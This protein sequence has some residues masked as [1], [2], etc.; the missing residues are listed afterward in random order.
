[1]RGTLPRL[2]G[3]GCWVAFFAD[4]LVFIL[5]GLELQVFDEG[6]V[7]LRDGRESEVRGE[8]GWVVCA[9]WRNSQFFT[10][11]PPFPSAPARHSRTLPPPRAAADVI[12]IGACRSLKCTI[13]PLPLKYFFGFGRDPGFWFSGFLII[14]DS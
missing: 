9:R 10:A 4:D 6:R 1:M 12:E 5:D 11:L 7:L 8:N 13:S 14:A 2:A 3:T